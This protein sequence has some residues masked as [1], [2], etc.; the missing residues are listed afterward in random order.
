MKAFLL[1]VI[2]GLTGSATASPPQEGSPA[3]ST[4]AE[5]VAT[6]E[7][8]ADVIL[9]A[10][11][12]E[13]NLVRSILATAYTHARAVAMRARA[14]IEAG[15][16]VKA[17][18][19]RLATLVSQ[20]ANEGDAAVAAV[21]KRLLEGGH[22]HNAEGER[23]GLYDEGFVIVTRAAKKSFLDSANRIARMAA[24]PDASELV[25]EWQK[26]ADEYERL[27]ASME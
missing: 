6:Y 12:S 17:D 20:L 3:T 14:G 11:E 4:P 5:L 7:S 26:V 24:D 23:Q 19:E 21:R 16:D 2:L 25:E 8:L 10:K 1:I 22:H 13:E 18:L 15:E 27:M 9:S